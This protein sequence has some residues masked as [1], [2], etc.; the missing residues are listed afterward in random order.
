MKPSDAP[1]I[2][3]TT[4]SDDAGKT[5]TIDFHLFDESAIK[6][7]DERQRGQ[8]LLDLLRARPSPSHM[9]SRYGE[10]VRNLTTL[11]D[12]YFLQ[13][14]HH[15]NV[16]CLTK[17]MLTDAMAHPEA[18]P[19]LTIRVSGYAVHFSRLTREQQLEVIARTFHDQI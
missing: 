1:V 19:G 12:G 5:T 9:S 11:L 16:N 14:G 18:Y 17:E 2:T 7:L 3:M 4:S 8:L 13:G 6:D 10:R 15:L